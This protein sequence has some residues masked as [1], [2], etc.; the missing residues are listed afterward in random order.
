MK[1]IALLILLTLSGCTLTYKGPA[2]DLTD[3]TDIRNPQ[4]H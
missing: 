3:F 2:Y 1:F 4:K